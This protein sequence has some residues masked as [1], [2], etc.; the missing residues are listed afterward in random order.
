LAGRAG[1]NW[2]EKVQNVVAESTAGCCDTTTE[3]QLE[4]GVV[5]LEEQPR[6]NECARRNSLSGV[7]RFEMLPVQAFQ[8]ETLAYL[9]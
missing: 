2:R 3:R 7:T 8:V 9:E 5:S 6:R 4:R 1:E